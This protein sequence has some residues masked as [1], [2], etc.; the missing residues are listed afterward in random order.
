MPEATVD[1]QEARTRA[2]LRTKITPVA[3]PLGTTIPTREQKAVELG[4]KVAEQR[5]AEESESIRPQT[6]SS[7]EAKRKIQ[8]RFGG[9]ERNAG[10]VLADVALRRT[11]TAAIAND[12]LVRRLASEGYASLTPAEQD[13]IVDALSRGLD[14]LPGLNNVPAAGTPERRAYVEAW[15]ND[16]NNKEYFAVLLEEEGGV[17]ARGEGSQE[18]VDATKAIIAQIETEQQEL[19]GKMALAQ[20]EAEEVDREIKKFDRTHGGEIT[21]LVTSVDAA[22]TDVNRFTEQLEAIRVRLQLHGQ[23]KTALYGSYNIPSPD[24]MARVG[25]I[26]GSETTLATDE[27]DAIQKLAEAKVK[28]DRAKEALEKLQAQQDAL[29]TRKEGVTA[30]QQRLLREFKEKGLA[31]EGA[32]SSLIMA[33]GGVEVLPDKI[34]SSVE[35]AFVKLI[36]K[37]MEKD[38]ETFLVE[39]QQMETDAKDEPT[40]TLL[41]GVRNRY[42]KKTRARGLE[43]IVRGHESL[44]LDKKVVGDDWGEYLT[45]GPEEVVRKV[46]EDSGMNPADI[47]TNMAN[48]EFMKNAIPQVM[49]QLITLRTRTGS[50]ISEDEAVYTASFDWAEKIFDKAIANNAKAK[51]MVDALQAQGIIEGKTL[52]SIRRA[53]KATI[54]K[55]LL[56]AFGTAA[57]GAGV[58]GVGGLAAMGVGG[59]GVA[60][61]LGIRN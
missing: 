26:A 13:K 51:E 30:E 54:L 38:N 49:E 42:F 2:A 18:E 57:I 19:K 10:G 53:D 35:T 44:K 45:K 50:K 16:P 58:L 29:T 22:Q 5:S 1:V 15:I 21:T 36:E 31:L 60:G 55:I 12:T 9:K 3:A 28:L 61:S 7:V 40:K 34:M 20:E 52:S 11:E 23:E 47:T 41:K 6:L 37:R 8:E 14:R 56:A 33:T 4:Q 48:P 24:K 17:V 59:A 25:A 32:Y 43:G 27:Q 39:L 46:L